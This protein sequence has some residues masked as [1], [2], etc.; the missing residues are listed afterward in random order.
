[1]LGLRNTSK[2]IVATLTFFTR[3]PLWRWVGVEAE[4]YRHVVPLWPLAGW[5]TGGVM[6]LVFWGA[7][8]LGCPLSVGVVLT[9]ASR[10][11]LTGA[12]H[13]DGLADFCDGFGGGTGRE[14]TLQIMKDSHIGTFGVLG[15]VG[16]SLLMWNVLVALMGRGTS[17]WVFLAVDALSKY[18]ASTIIYFLPYARPESESKNRYTYS[19]ATT[20]ERLLSLLLGFLPLGI[21][22]LAGL[23][24]MPRWSSWASGLTACFV[25]LFLLYRGMQRRIGGYTGDCCGATVLLTEL[26]LYLTLLLVS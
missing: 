12:L 16:Y 5:F 3:L 19:A 1:M 15:L 21:C 8:S 13:E 7:T 24:S 23:P 10:V 26:T 9:L 11:L 20:T 14:R 25:L 4:H 6:V 18:L 22:L 17:P 2:R